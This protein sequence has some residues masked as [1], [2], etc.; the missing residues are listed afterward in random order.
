MKKKFFAVIVLLLVLAAV[1]LVGSVTRSISDFQDNKETLIRNSNG[2]YWEPIGSNIQA[3]ID[4]LGSGGTVWLPAG[5]IELTSN[6][7]PRNNVRIIGNGIGNTVISSHSSIYPFWL[8]NKHNVTLTDFTINMHNIGGNAINFDSGTSDVI[9]KN[10]QILNPGANGVRVSNA[11][12]LFIS[13]ILVDHVKWPDGGRQG[14]SILH[15]YDSIFDNCIVTN[16]DDAMG[17][18]LARSQNCQVNNLIVKNCS[19]SM[20]VVGEPGEETKKCSL[21]N[22]NI[23]G[24]TSGAGLKIQYTENSNFNNILIKSGNGGTGL[25]IYNTCKNLNFNNVQIV[26]SSGEGFSIEGTGMNVNNVLV[27]NPTYYGLAIQNAENVK[28]SNFQSNSAGS[29]NRM[30]GSQNVEIT[31]S[32]FTGG[33]D[34]GMYIRSSNNF[35]IS[36]SRFEDNARDGIGLAN[37]GTPCE[38]FIISDNIITGN[39][40]DGI[41]IRALPSGTHD[42]FIITNNDLTGN[43]EQGV[44]DDSTGSNKLVGDNLT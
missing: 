5:T 26:S 6:T 4:D 38:Q 7:V 15:A 35:I 24:H 3:A 27:D 20:K 36:G 41:N 33:I 21:N 28:V 19:Y 39:S 12:R 34:Y 8:S 18:D 44:D 17:F 14:F 30:F 25:S 43:T 13:N 37:D 2:N 11:S 31:D 23:L 16:C 10:V 40:W 9:F 1:Y 32:S 42:N 29:Y 22:I